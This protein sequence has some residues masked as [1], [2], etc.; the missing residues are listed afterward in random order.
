MVASLIMTVQV[1]KVSKISDHDSNIAT[2]NTTTLVGMA[3]KLRA[4]PPR[5][6]SRPRE[7]DKNSSGLLVQFG[8]SAG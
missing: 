1:Y 6:K 3:I 5:K 4:L 7:L 8:N 2:S